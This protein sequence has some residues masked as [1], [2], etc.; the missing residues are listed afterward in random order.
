MKRFV[1]MVAFVLALAIFVV[2]PV[3]AEEVETRASTYFMCSNVYLYKTSTYNFEAWF[4]V[5]AYDI[6]DELGANSIAIQR[7]SDGE[8]W[9]TMGT[10]SKANY[11]QFICKN[12]GSHAACLLYAGTPGY[13]YRAKI[14]LYAKDSRGTGQLVR[15]TSKML[16]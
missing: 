5:S 3:Q 7:S 4:S 9:T 15:Y 12:T 10:F 14:T 6:M 2:V 11:S 16:L 8:N 13:Y 1:K